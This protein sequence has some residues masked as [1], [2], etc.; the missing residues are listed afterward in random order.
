MPMIDKITPEQP[1]QGA[2]QPIDNASGLNHNINKLRI[3]L[4]SR[5]DYKCI[6][7]H[8]EGGDQT[9]RSQEAITPDD[10]KVIT[11]AATSLGIRRF[12]ITGGE[13]FL[14][15]EVLAILEEIKKVNKGIDV[16][17]TTNGLLIGE[18]EIAKLAEYVSKISLN[19]QGT[20]DRSSP[21]R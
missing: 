16:S 21:N 11:E 5:C 1:Q 4:T 2:N 7:C 20:D 6:F 10:V 8:N 17:I 12:T 18:H 13:P 15:H 3:S 19:F 14:N 9:R